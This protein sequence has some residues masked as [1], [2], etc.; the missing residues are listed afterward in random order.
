MLRASPLRHRVA[1]SSQWNPVQY[2]INDDI[3]FEVDIHEFR[4]GR[5]QPHKWV[6]VLHRRAASA[7]RRG[8]MTGGLE[9]Q[10]HGSSCVVWLCKFAAVLG[11]DTVCKWRLGAHVAYLYSCCAL[12]GR[13]PSCKL[14]CSDTVACSSK[15]A[16]II[17]QQAA[18]L[19]LVSVKLLPL[20][21]LL[22]PGCST[23]A[24]KRVRSR[25]D[26]AVRPPAASCWQAPGH[27]PFGRML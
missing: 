2:R 20:S 19:Q 1:G 12:L 10:Q 14:D 15:Q 18:E 7:C 23:W 22:S 26:H 6:A 5:W 9:P 13:T 27:P 17:P 3:E 4:N 11:T 16:C 24:A 8:N 21:L 25:V